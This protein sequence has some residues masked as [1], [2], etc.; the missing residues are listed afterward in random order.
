VELT[1]KGFHTMRSFVEIAIRLLA[2]YGLVLIAPDMVTALD[3][4]SQMDVGTQVLAIILLTI[5]GTMIP[6]CLWLMA[7]RIA[8][9]VTKGETQDAT[10]SFN[11][12]LSDALFLSIIIIGLA[13][14]SS[15]ATNLGQ[16]L[17]WF[18]KRPLVNESQES[19]LLIRLQ[20]DLFVRE[21]LIMLMV[22]ASLGVFLLLRAR[23][24]ADR[25]LKKYLGGS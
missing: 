8:G 12:S 5:V 25:M 14:L 20:Y 11:L 22:R 23:P 4:M 3:R 6:A 2:V 10:G 7:P 1:D 18:A 9:A 19:E 15:A 24:L 16:V 13:V 21:H 17:F